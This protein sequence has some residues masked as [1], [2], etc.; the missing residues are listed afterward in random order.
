MSFQLKG[1]LFGALCDD[2]CTEA[3][4]GAEVR[5]YL[6][7]GDHVSDAAAAAEKDTFH[8]LEEGARDGDEP[9]GVGTVG[10][11][12]SFTVEVRVDTEQGKSYGGEAVDV[13]V[14]CGTVPRPRVDPHGPVQF[15]ITTLQPQWR[16]SENGNVAAWS[17]T[18]PSRFW[19]F[20]LGLFGIWTICGRLTTCADKTPI[21]G[22]TVKAFDA[23]WLQDDAL[24]SA[25]TDASGHFLISYLTA[26]FRRTPWSPF[27]NIELVGGPDVYFTATLGGTPIL[28]EGQAAGRQPGR[29]NIG[30]CYCVDLCTDKVVPPDATPHWQQVEAFD[31]HPAP[32]L[33]GAS[34]TTDGDTVSGHYFFGGG[35]TLR[36]NCPLLD[37]GTG[38]ALEYRF[39]VGEYTWTGGTDDPGSL[40]TVAPATMQPL[41]QL[42]AA[43]V[44]YVF[45]TDG[46]GIS[47]SQAVFV[48]A[49]DADPNGWVSVDNKPV[50]VQMYNPPG[51]TA[52]VNVSTA[53]F[54]RTFDLAVVNTVALTSVH[55][56]KLSPGLT[57]ADAGR[58]L[59]VAEREPVRRYQLGFE[60]RDATTHGPV[61]WSD[62]LSAIVFDNSPVQVAL[63]LEELHANACNPLHGVN[64]LHLLYTVD[65]PMLRSFDMTISSNAGTSHTSASLGTKATPAGAYTSGMAFPWFRGNHSG[66]HN[67]TSTGGQIVDISADPTCAYSVNLSWVTRRWTDTG[68]STNVLYCH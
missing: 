7:K 10:A 52:V 44:G 31:I 8:V 3:L 30:H 39:T 23:D 13:D 14:Y 45:Y 33:P 43:H 4:A 62:Q 53:N 54:L 19:C 48:G 41:T 68:Q 2:G 16:E 20:I 46:N 56:P 32:G 65:H 51:S 11:D 36:G 1:A 47:Q 35:V 63:D 22:A 60:V 18:I 5:L 28:T 61:M 9:L 57:K 64:D 42:G 66:P 6:A 55:P 50:T 49:A 58:D 17:Y 37:L 29:Q 34:F 21:P 26:D 40:P 38:H 59:L 24:G 25:N 67:G 27:L 12:G 15:T